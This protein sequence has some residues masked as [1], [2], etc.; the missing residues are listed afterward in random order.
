MTKIYILL[1]IFAAVICSSTGNTVGQI[2]LSE[3]YQTCQSVDLNQDRFVCEIHSQDDEN[4]LVCPGVSKCKM[5]V[6]LCPDGSINKT[7]FPIKVD[8]S[9]SYQCICHSKR[10]ADSIVPVTE[11]TTWTTSTNPY[12]SFIYERSLTVPSLHWDVL[13]EFSDYAPANVNIIS[14]YKLATSVYSASATWNGG[15]CAAS[16]AS[17]DFTLD[18]MACSWVGTD[19]PHWLQMSLPTE[20][21]VSGVLIKQRCDSCCHNQYATTVKITRSADGSSWEIVIDSEDLTYDSY[22]GHGSAIVWFPRA[23]IAKYWRIQILNYNAH[24][25]MKADLIGYK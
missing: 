22:D 19:P 7:C 13:Q 20:Y 21:V 2:L 5:P 18:V 1:S 4:S 9:L 15:C 6:T 24:P 8:Y 3:S 17:I 10:R 23:H 11:W 14:Y 12:Q 16:R 25:S